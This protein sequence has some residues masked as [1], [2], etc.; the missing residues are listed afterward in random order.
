MW[1]EG[2]R[3][4]RELVVDVSNRGFEN[5]DEI[6]PGLPLTGCVLEAGDFY[7]ETGKERSDIIVRG[8]VGDDRGGYGGG[9]R[10]KGGWAVL[11]EGVLVGSSVVEGISGCTDKEGVLI[12]RGNHSDGSR[13]PTRG[14]SLPLRRGQVWRVVRTLTNCLER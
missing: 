2:G 4:G 12:S 11:A 14:G 8:A 6:A 3:G 1:A 13:Q 10:W 7:S 5:L 9:D